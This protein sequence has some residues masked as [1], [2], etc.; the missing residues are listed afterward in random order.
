MVVV[1]FCCIFDCTRTVDSPMYCK[2]R[3][4]LVKTVVFFYG[5]QGVVMVK[6]LAIALLGALSLSVSANTVVD[7]GAWKASFDPSFSGKQ[8]RCSPRKTCG[9]MEDCEEACYH[10]VTCKNRRLD[11]DKD[12]IPCESICDEACEN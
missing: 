12:G 6:L 4:L 1:G 9:K 7:V 2:C 10:L 3:C 5:L 11:R 8:Y